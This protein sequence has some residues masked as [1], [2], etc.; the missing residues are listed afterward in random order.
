VVFFRS[1]NLINLTFQVLR[2]I[3]WLT[4]STTLSCPCIQETII[5]AV[6]YRFTTAFISFTSVLTFCYVGDGIE[7][8]IVALSQNTEWKQLLSVYTD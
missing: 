3:L 1:P 4:L 6:L 2:L 8:L 7:P 5:L